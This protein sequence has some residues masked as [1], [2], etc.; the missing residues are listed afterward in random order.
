MPPPTLGSLQIPAM[1]V[2]GDSLVDPGNNNPLYTFAK[3][4]Y[5]PY[6]VDFPLGPTGRFCNGATVADQ[7]G[8]MLGLLL[9]PA[10][11]DP[12]TRGPNIL[13]GVSYASSSSGILNDTG[14]QTGQIIPLSQQVEHFGQKTVPELRTLALNTTVEDFLANSLFFCNNGNNDF[15]KNYLLP[16]GN[17]LN[18]EVPPEF[19]DSLA[20]EYSI[21]LKKLY[22]YGARKFIVS[23]LAPL[24]CIPMVIAFYS[25]DTNQCYEHHNEVSRKFSAK[26]KTMVQQLNQDLPGAS[27]LYLDIY[28]IAKKAIDN[29]S[30]YGFKYSHTA[31]CGGG[32]ANGLVQ[33]SPV[34]LICPKRAEYFFWDPFHPT[35]A[36]VKFLAKEAYDGLVQSM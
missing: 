21:R 5:P 23:G 10:F 4:N 11:N 22:S 30:D 13:Q 25:N 35:E 8:N 33:C 18:Q 16:N 24:G 19:Y 7:L 27:I 12:S 29:P 36:A 3:A 6:G 1:F 15:L 20:H 28:N 32:R 31:C 9:I 14:A 34:S 17:L 26:I 2:F